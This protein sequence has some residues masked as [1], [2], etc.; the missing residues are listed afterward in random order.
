MPIMVNRG[1]VMVNGIQRL[2]TYHYY[3]CRH[4]QRSIRTTTNNP[5]EILCLYCLGQVEYELDMSRPRL[6]LDNGLEPSPAARILDSLAQMFDPPIR[7]HPNLDE[8]NHGR[9]QA[10]V[11]LQFIGPEHPPRPVSPNENMISNELIQQLTQNNTAPGQPPAPDSAVEALPVVVLTAEHLANDDSQCPICKDEFEI[12]TEGM[13]GLSPNPK[14][15]IPISR[16]GPT[17]TH[18]ITA[19]GLRLGNAVFHHRRLHL[20]F[21]LHS[22]LKNISCLGDVPQFKDMWYEKALQFTGCNGF[23]W[24][25]DAFPFL[26]LSFFNGDETRSDSKDIGKPY[27]STSRRALFDG[28]QWTNILLAANV[29][30]YIAQTLTEGKVLFWGAK[31]NSLIDKGQLWRLATSS[32]LHANIVHL[33]VNCYSL[34]SVGPTVEKICGPRRY[35]TIYVTSAIAS[36]AMSYWFSKAP[37][38]G[39]SGA[40]F[41]LVGSFAM[42]ILR[43]R[44]MVKGSE[45]DLQHIAHVIVLNMAIGLLSKGI[46]NWGHV[47]G[48]IG[49]A[50]VSWLLGPAWKVESVSRNG[51]KVFTDKAPIFSL[52]KRSTK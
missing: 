10:L 3:W 24:S 16:V 42:F 25:H 15:S 51:R 5:A 52:I 41:G 43:H 13:G 49:G 34:N 40:I 28:R 18:L 19:A 14:F 45:G 35:L 2:R 46:D 17:P 32:F 50:A 39:A 21:L 7:Q 23:Q 30:V 33:M 6:G 22:S 4:C 47:G 37:A 20:G 11:L 27:S 8:G 31:I 26:S 38:V 1:R 36:S 44:G 12:G 48:L 9:H 29:L